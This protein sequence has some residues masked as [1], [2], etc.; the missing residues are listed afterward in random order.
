MKHPLISQVSQNLMTKKRDGTDSHGLKAGPYM[1]PAGSRKRSGTL[2]LQYLQHVDCPRSEGRG[3]RCGPGHNKGR[4]FDASGAPGAN[5]CDPIKG[6]HGMRR[7]RGAFLEATCLRVFAVPIGVAAGRNRGIEIIHPDARRNRCRPR[8][9]PLDPRKNFISRRLPALRRGQSS[10]EPSFAFIPLE[11]GVLCPPRVGNKSFRGG[12]GGTVFKM[13]PQSPYP[14]TE[15]FLRGWPRTGR[16]RI[17]FPGECQ[18][19]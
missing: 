2:P 3:F 19:R 1:R 11:A 15:D 16:M 18:G 10:P 7:S 13:S 12:S 4:G 6:I 5:H 9:P 17:S 8:L 14:K